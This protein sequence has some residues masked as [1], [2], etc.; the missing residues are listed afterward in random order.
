MVISH[1][2]ELVPA[3]DVHD[4]ERMAFLLERAVDTL[5]QFADFSGA[6]VAGKNGFQPRAG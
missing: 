1:G 3:A 5:D 6:R 2:L 4:F